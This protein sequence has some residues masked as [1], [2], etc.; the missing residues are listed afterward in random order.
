MSDKLTNGQSFHTFNKFDGYNREGS[1]IE[2]DSSLPSA[3]VIRSLEQ[4]INVVANLPLSV[5][6][7]PQNT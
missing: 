3:R 2:A 4:I 6:I 5:V 1:C 7:M